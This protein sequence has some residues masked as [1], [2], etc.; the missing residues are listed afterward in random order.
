MTNYITNSKRDEINVARRK[1]YHA[2]KHLKGRPSTWH[3]L[4]EIDEDKMTAICQQCGPTTLKLR[5]SR[6]RC[7][8]ATQSSGRHWLYGISDEEFQTLLIEQNNCCAICGV[9][10]D[11][12]KINVDH[13]HGTGKVRGLLCPNCNSGIG[14]L[15]DDVKLLLIAVE[16][17]EGS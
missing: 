14:K 5:G 1:K 13:E 7:I 15:H 10:F 6:L 11:L 17:L 12:A 4:S 3:T 2:T 16:Y 9:S 8:K